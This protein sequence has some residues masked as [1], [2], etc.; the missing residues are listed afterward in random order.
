LEV[1]DS[2]Q[3]VGGALQLRVSCHVVDAFVPE[4]HLSI[5]GPKTLQELLPSSRCHVI[6]ST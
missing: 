2:G 1:E 6:A 5:A 3:A 4:P